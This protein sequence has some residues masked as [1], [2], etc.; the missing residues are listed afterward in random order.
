MAKKLYCTGL[1]AMSNATENSKT[2]AAQYRTFIFFAA[3]IMA[4]LALFVWMLSNSTQ[5][6]HSTVEK[7]NFSD[8]LKHADPESIV[9]EKVQRGIEDTKKQTE[10]LKKQL[11]DQIHSNGS[12]GDSKQ[13]ELEERIASIE[14]KM[15]SNQM[16]VDPNNSSA[17]SGSQQYQGRLLPSSPRQQDMTI[18]QPV[19]D[20]MREDKLTV[21]SVDP[22]KLRPTKNPDTY[23]PSGTFAQAVMLS[24]ADASAAVTS[25]H[26]PNPMLFR[27]ISNGTLPNHKKS[28]LKDC[29]MTGYVVGDISSE[30]GEINIEKLSC[31]F[32][33]DQ[34]IDKKVEGWIFGRDGKYGERGTPVWR[35]GALLGRAAVAGTLSGIGRGISQSYVTNQ[36]SPLGTTQTVNN[37]DI[38]K[39]GLA[40]GGS[41]S[42]KALADYNIKRAEQYHP[43]IQ[44]SPGDVVD[45][46][47]KEGFFLDEK[48]HDQEEENKNVPNMFDVPATTTS[49]YAEEKMLP[50]SAEQVRRIQEN[51]KQLGFKVTGG[52]N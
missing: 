28:H 40:Q 35:E 8:P 16:E 4:V 11:S 31:S 19:D 33:N 38:F 9:L 7:L 29:L 48:K 15:G 18:S 44:I 41:D 42:M 10:E 32:A 17:L 46:V 22:T 5:D 37:G 13:K 20:S 49:P 27:I 52:T 34:I 1:S 43:V 50:L 3:V 30:R 6:S 21:T 36:I 25:P 24:G 47:F 51:N 12:V 45:V 39:S 14:K 26:N 2:K 23:V